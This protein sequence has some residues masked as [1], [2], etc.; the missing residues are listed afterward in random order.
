[1]GLPAVSYSGWFALFAP[2][3]TPKD[4]IAKLNAAAVGALADPGVQSRITGHRQRKMSP[5]ARWGPAP[6]R[7]GAPHG[8]V[9]CA[10][11]APSDFVFA[12]SRRRIAINFV[13]GT[14]YVPAAL[15]GS[16]AAL[17]S[18]NP[19]TRRRAVEYRQMVRTVQASSLQSIKLRHTPQKSGLSAWGIA[20]FRANSFGFSAQTYSCHSPKPGQ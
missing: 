19:R 13:T 12:A 16:P 8:L 2:R 1:M 7:P 5:H 17:A 4:I 11:M 15:H 10:E 14:L 3:G 18:T 20:T 9:M 6:F